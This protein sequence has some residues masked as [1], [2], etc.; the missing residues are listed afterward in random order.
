MTHFDLS[1]ETIAVRAGDHPDPTTG[2]VLTP[3]FQSTTYAQEAV[4]KDRGH[5]YSRV[6]NPTVS[7][8]EEALGALEGAPPAVCCRTGMAAITTLLLT[9]LKGGDHLVVSDV[10]YGG[11]VRLVREILAP[12]GI[13]HDFVDTADPAAVERALRRSTRLVLVET[14]ANPTLKLTDVPAVAAHTRARGVLLAVDNTFLTP[15]LFRPLDHGAD[16]AVYS[17]TK[18]LEGHNSTV[19]GSLTTRDPELLERL[20]RVRKTLGVIQAPQDAWLTLRGLKTLVLRMRRH[21]ESA[22]ELA[23]R[24]ARHPRVTAVH[25]PGLPSFPQAELARRQHAAHGGIVAFEVEGGVE[26]GKALLEHVRLCILAENLG[27]AETLLTHPASMTHSDV[28][29]EQRRATGITDGL[30]RL[31]VGLEDP[32]DLYRD[33]DQALARLTGTPAA[34]AVPTLSGPAQPEGVP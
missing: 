17:T 1:F 6:S 10:V 4:G 25:Y 7:A 16:I 26:A 11:T 32:D 19:G 14:P 31:S 3:V 9:V 34:H 8:L 2:A 29:A 30:I 13:A 28:P 21:S 5:T 27:A 18:Y 15:A 22:L 23:Q 24:L 33:L 12:L 20:H